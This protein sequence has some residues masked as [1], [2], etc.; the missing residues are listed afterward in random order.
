MNMVFHIASQHSCF[1]LIACMHGYEH[2]VFISSAEQLLRHAAAV[3]HG[4]APGHGWHQRRRSRLPTDQSPRQK[5]KL[6]ALRHWRTYTCVSCSWSGKWFVGSG[7]SG[8]RETLSIAVHIAGH[9]DRRHA[10]DTMLAVLRSCSR[11]RRSRMMLMSS[12]T[13]ILKRLQQAITKCVPPN[14]QLICKSTRY[15]ANEPYEC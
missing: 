8:N 4:L 15:D 13:C 12:Q 7:G 3:R 10:Q 11:V 2:D 9:I 6:K 1:V 5:L 14:M